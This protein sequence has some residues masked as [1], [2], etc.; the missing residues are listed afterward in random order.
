MHA[1]ADGKMVLQQFAYTA[2]P[3]LDWLRATA[4]PIASRRVEAARYAAI[5]YA[6]FKL[7][8]M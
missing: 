8:L 6:C 2:T 3:P 1:A 5:I 7:A 4:M